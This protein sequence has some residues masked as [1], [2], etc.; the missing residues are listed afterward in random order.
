MRRDCIK[1][2]RGRCGIGDSGEEKEGV[3]GCVE[4]NFRNRVP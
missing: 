3:S 4:R 1:G 2:H